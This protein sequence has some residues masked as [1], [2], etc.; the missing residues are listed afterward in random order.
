MVLTWENLQ[1]VFLVL[2]QW[3]FFIHCFSMSSFTLPWAIARFLLPFYT[4]SAA[5]RRVIRDTFI[6]NFLDLSVTAY[7]ERYGF[8]PA[9]FTFHSF[10]TLWHIFQLRC[11]QE[12]PIQD[13]PLCLPPQSCAFRLTHGLELL[14]L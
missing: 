10:P 3:R 5:H 8:E 9:F 1:K 4:L 14:I 11:G 6:L 7:R 12:H 2:P 13:P